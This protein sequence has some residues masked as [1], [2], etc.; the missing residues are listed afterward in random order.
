[1]EWLNVVKDFG[2]L[3]LLI[4]FIIREIW[5]Q[6]KN[7]LQRQADIKMENMRLDREKEL[8]QLKA[9]REE[10]AS[11]L[12]FRR[13]INER[14]TAAYEE[15]VK[16]HQAQTLVL[17]AI[18]ERLNQMVALQQLISTHLV[19]ATS[20]MRETVARLHPEIKPKE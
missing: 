1:M 12:A 13:A 20:N 14:L 19:D 4:L 8:E 7:T 18:N 5:P 3:G 6:A 2:W 9:D 16:A 15:L 10:R 11:D 17:T